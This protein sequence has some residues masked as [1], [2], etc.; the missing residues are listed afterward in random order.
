M[1][2]SIHADEIRLLHCQLAMTVSPQSIRIKA[3]LVAVPYCF[4]GNGRNGNTGFACS[5]SGAATNGSDACGF[6]GNLYPSAC[7][8]SPATCDTSRYPAG[9]NNQY[10]S[11]IRIGCYADEGGNYVGSWCCNH[12]DGSFTEPCCSDNIFSRFTSYTDDTMVGGGGGY[13]PPTLHTEILD[14]NTCLSSLDGGASGFND[15][16][17]GCANLLQDPSPRAIANALLD[18][19]D[20]TT[21]A[22]DTYS[23]TAPPIDPSNHGAWLDTGIVTTVYPIVPTSLPMFLIAGTNLADSHCWQCGN[24]YCD[25]FAMNGV[26][27]YNTYITDIGPVFSNFVNPYGYEWCVS[28]V[29]IQIQGCQMYAC[30][31]NWGTTCVPTS[32]QC[33]S[34]VNDFCFGGSAVCP[35]ANS[36]NTPISGTVITLTVSAGT[37]GWSMAHIWSNNT[38]VCSTDP[39]PTTF[40]DGTTD[41]C[42][43]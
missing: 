39:H 2:W 16:I 12:E 22:W 26:F 23:I 41:T 11:A 6:T 30:E 31:K 1:R 13:F 40:A 9:A 18:D 7:N 33:N 35:T 5:P 8:P 25:I 36:V 34:G 19:I 21:Y 20:L 27:P 42:C 28:K 10:G 14:T 29:E 37:L 38:G 15:G 43:P 3:A 17:G 32:D 24:N 4:N